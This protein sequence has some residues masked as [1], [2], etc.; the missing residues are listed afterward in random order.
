MLLEIHSFHGL[1]TLTVITTQI[2]CLA[3]R[4]ASR[5]DENQGGDRENNRHSCD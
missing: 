3:V 5:P 2:L 1:G 4:L